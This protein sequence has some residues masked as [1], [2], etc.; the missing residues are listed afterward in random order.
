MSP[1]DVQDLLRFCGSVDPWLGK[2]TPEEGAVM[3]AGWTL[4]LE[5]IPGDVA[6]RAARAHYQHG[7]ARTITPGDLL[8][9][10]AGERRREQQSTTDAIAA[11]SIQQALDA[12]VGPAIFGSGAQY[13]ADMMAVVAQGGDPATVV[14]PAGVRVRMLSPSAEARER[15]CAF[16]DICVCT[17]LECRGGWLDTEETVVNG[18]G[19]HYPAARY[20]PQCLDG[21]KMAG[22]KGVARRPRKAQ[23]R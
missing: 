21:V 5:A 10:W 17:H 16:P 19:R 18:L 13:L 14:R 2:T 7:E 1:T 6:M 15:S 4:M 9:A 23:A 20:C 3:V 22:E 12:E 8:D 11:A